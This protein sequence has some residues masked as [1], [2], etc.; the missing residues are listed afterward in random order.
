MAVVLTKKQEEIFVDDDEDYELVS[1][2]TW[3]LNT[4]GYAVTE[5]RHKQQKMHRMI[6]G[7][8]D[9][10]VFVDHIN[11]NPVDNRKSNLRLCTNAENCRNQKVHKNSQSGVK[12]LYYCKRRNQWKA[13]I[14]LQGKLH[15][16]SFACKKHGE[17][18][19]KEKAIQWLEE[20]R[21]LL[22]G[23]FARS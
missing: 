18:L 9:P 1:K 8:T 23:Q 6:M 11:G 21:P 4:N 22:H 14:M 7:V 20:N 10:K 17:K 3:Y 5:I 2:H 19:A 15:R 13:E 12:G 16:K